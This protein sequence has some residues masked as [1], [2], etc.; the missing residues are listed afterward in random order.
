MNRRNPTRI[1][2]KTDDMT[3]EFEPARKEAEE[4][5]GAAKDVAVGTEKEAGNTPTATTAAAAP[6]TR[7]SGFLERL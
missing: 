6:R 7:G 3:H 2:L 5:K 4:S 1:E